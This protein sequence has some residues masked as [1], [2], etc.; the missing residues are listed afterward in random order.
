MP[1]VD[2]QNLSFAYEG[3]IRLFENVSFRLDHGRKAALVGGNGAGKSTLL[4]LLTGV[5]TPDSGTVNVNGEVVLV[6]QVAPPIEVLDD[7]AMTVEDW[8]EE[9][10]VLGSLDFELVH[11]I[12][13]ALTLPPKS[14]AATLSE[15][16]RF[17]LHL[18]LAVLRP[19]VDLLLLDEPTSHLDLSTVLFLQEFVHSTSTACII[20]SHDALFL[21]ATVNTIFELDAAKHSLRSTSASYSDYIKARQA[22]QRS[23]AA[24][25][26]SKQRKATAIEAQV[27]RL[28]SAG[29]R[30]THHDTG[31]RDKLLR[32]YQ[33]DRAGRSLKAAGVRQ[34]QQQRL[35]AEKGD[36]DVPGEALPF[37]L[38]LHYDSEPGDLQLD[39]AHSIALSDAILGHPDG[40]SYGP[41][42]V[43]V[44]VGDKLL[45]L[46]QNGAG[47]S[48]LL[49]SL[50][51]T[52]PLKSGSLTCG[53][54]IRLGTLSQ[55]DTCGLD[56]EKTPL[57]LIDAYAPLVN[58]DGQLG[59]LADAGIWKDAAIRPA[60]LLSPG[61]RVRL[62]LLL[63]VLR[64]IN[65]LILDEVTNYIDRAAKD[66]LLEFLP[67][68]SGA[69]ICVSHD[70]ELVSSVT[71]SRILRLGP[72][73]TLTHMT[74]IQLEE[75]LSIAQDAA[76]ESMRILFDD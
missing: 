39:T 68:F 44:S 60:R 18:C 43:S 4:K 53:R 63:L 14:P 46:G 71:W 42:S 45:I 29:T 40:P 56:V 73:A 21:Q 16:Q 32:D 65:V 3:G 25:E 48:T 20:V 47:K 51:G 9:Q 22:R 36:T 72:K 75:R 52:L 67:S 27:K 8:L 15:G 54:D 34:R 50:N 59:R 5:I 55:D 1:V 12:L 11:K 64:K 70:R 6:P 74:T 58:S 2:V 61:L 10:C 35:L 13:R 19:G 24:F 66:V 23:A 38:I 62:A 49:A 76:S 31:D 57:Q 69:V 30:G 17:K 7:L 26:A 41:L 37:Q 28:Q 33:R